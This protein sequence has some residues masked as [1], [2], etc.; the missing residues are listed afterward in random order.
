MKFNIT[1]TNKGVIQYILPCLA[2]VSVLVSCT[3]FLEEKP[4][5]NL[6]SEYNF[7]TAEEGNA[8]AVA[9]YRALPAVYTVFFTISV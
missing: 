2:M 3:K 7:K 9:G 1:K 8:L 5:A 6:T 4:T